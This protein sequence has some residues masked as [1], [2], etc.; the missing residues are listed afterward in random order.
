MG[1]FIGSNKDKGHIQEQQS[2]TEW[3]RTPRRFIYSINAYLLSGFCVLSTVVSTGVS[4][5]NNK[6]DR[7]PW[8]LPSNGEAEDTQVNG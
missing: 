8:R 7:V 2:I 1:K 6:T 3:H 5:V 4:A